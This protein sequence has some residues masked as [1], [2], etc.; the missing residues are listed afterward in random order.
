MHKFDDL[1]ELY[2]EFEEELSNENEY[3]MAVFWNSY[4]DMVQILR[5]FAK[6]IKNGDWDLHMFASEKMLHW[7]HSYDHYNYARHFSYYWASQQA[8]A[9]KHSSIFTRF[10]EGDFSIRRSKGKFNKVSPDKVI[11]QTI[12]KDQKGPSNLII[13]WIM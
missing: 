8:L 4:L 11:E 3:P 5:D 1:F 10:K 13:F 2:N 12:N 9:G 6:S 7:Y